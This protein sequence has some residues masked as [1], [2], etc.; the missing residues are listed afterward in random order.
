VIEFRLYD[1]VRADS[2]SILELTNWLLGTRILP[3]RILL[4]GGTFFISRGIIRLVDP[5][6][7]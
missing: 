5:G 1:Q 3:H 4:P 2:F 6:F 7:V